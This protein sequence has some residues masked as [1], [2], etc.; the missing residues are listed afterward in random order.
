MVLTLEGSEVKYYFGAKSSPQ[1]S[2]VISAACSKSQKRKVI[3]STSSKNAGESLP[4][5]D[6]RMSVNPTKVLHFKGIPLSFQ[7]KY[8]VSQLVSMAQKPELVSKTT[9]LPYLDK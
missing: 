7:F 5:N 3:I 9:A 6:S 8:Q 1:I 4:N 2:K